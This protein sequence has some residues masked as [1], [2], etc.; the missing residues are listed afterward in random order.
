ML[1]KF[2]DPSKKTGW[3]QSFNF[4]Q[5]LYTKSDNPMLMRPLTICALNIT[6]SLLLHVLKHLAREQER[7][8]EKKEKMHLTKKGMFITITIPHHLTK[9]F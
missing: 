8:K 4:L 3:S 5:K 7:M 1:R 6:D 9:V 2:G